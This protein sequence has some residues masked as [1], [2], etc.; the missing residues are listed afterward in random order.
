MT[1]DMKTRYVVKGIGQEKTI[2]SVIKV[3]LNQQGKIERVEDRWDD[4]LPDGGIKNVSFLSPWSWVEYWGNWA[5]WAWS[6]V[7]WTR[8]WLVRWRI[9]W[10]SRNFVRYK[11]TR[12]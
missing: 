9:S 8:P 2:Q 7:W 6:F 11:R 10:Q 1:M 5:F 12:C 4:Q 3:W